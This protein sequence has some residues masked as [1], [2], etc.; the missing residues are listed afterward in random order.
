MIIPTMSAAIVLFSATVPLYFIIKVRHNRRVLI[1]SIMLVLVLVSY[2]FHA[3]L[4]S[5]WQENYELIRICF[6]ISIIGTILTYFL[7]NKKQI[8]FPIIGVYGISLFLVSVIWIGSE[9]IKLFIPS[10]AVVATYCISIAMI[11]FGILII[12]RF[13]W[14]RSQYHTLTNNP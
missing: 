12:S 11:G 6:I 1:S 2:A 4:E 8:I 9:T 5:V 10:Y 13:L 14:L 7:F 3:I